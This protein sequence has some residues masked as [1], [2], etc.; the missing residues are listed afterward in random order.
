MELTKRNDRSMP[1]GKRIS[2]FGVPYSV[3]A[4]SIDAEWLYRWPH[5]IHSHSHS[6]NC[7]SI[8]CPISVFVEPEKKARTEPDLLYKRHRWALSVFSSSHTHTH[9]PHSIHKLVLKLM[10]G[11]LGAVVRHRIDAHLILLT[12]SQTVLMFDYK[13]HNNINYHLATKRDNGEDAI[14]NGTTCE[15]TQVWRIKSERNRR[16]LATYLLTSNGKK[17]V[18]VVFAIR[19]RVWQQW[20]AEHEHIIHG[21]TCMCVFLCIESTRNATIANA[22]GY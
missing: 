9:A 19:F 20:G 5:S 7:T 17:G 18:N 10:V 4:I 15:L 13:L 21:S 2:A 22:T 6:P 3:F 8:A 16:A 11:M 1:L 14:R 12:V